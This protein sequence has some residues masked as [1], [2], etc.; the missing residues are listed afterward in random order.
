M[1]SVE[2]QNLLAKVQSLEH[3]VVAQG[4][5]IQALQLLVVDMKEMMNRF[6]HSNPSSSTSGKEYMCPLRCKSEG[7]T[8]VRL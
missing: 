1:A 3:V 8:K 4:V 6:L 7:F 2:T 5:T